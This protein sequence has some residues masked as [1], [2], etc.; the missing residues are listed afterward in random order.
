MR[1]AIKIDAASAVD[2]PSA[3]GESRIVSAAEGYEWWAPSYDHA[4]NPLLAREERY[5]SALLTD[6]HGKSSLDL[7]CG[8]G[9]WLEKLMEQGCASGVG[10]DYSSA[11]LRVAGEKPAI[12]GRLARA[13][14]NS[15]PLPS[16]CFDLAVCSFAMSHVHDLEPAAR[17]LGRV[18]KA[19]A[20]V[21]VT[22]L[23]FEA[24]A[25]GWRVGFRSGATAIQIETHPRTADEI[26]RVFGRNGLECKTHET[27]WLG[28]PERSIFERAGKSDSFAAACR[29]PAIL[30]CHFRRHESPPSE[31]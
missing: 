27:L 10:I 19:G 30:I 26:V 28:E 13:D 6:L 7:A 16:D 29:L 14:C 21:F 2:E 17:E 23:H 24:Y 8:T 22:D 3:L 15:L 25:R 11:M 31:N 18:T 20:D 9:R 5:L 12:R 1:A 4:P